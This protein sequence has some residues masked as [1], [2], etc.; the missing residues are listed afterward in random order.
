M[1][2]A[3][4]RRR[5]NSAV[6][7]AGVDLSDVSEHLLSATRDLACTYLAAEIHAVHV[8]PNEPI[9]LL[10]ERARTTAL[11]EIARVESAK[12]ELRRLC[13][14]IVG[15]RL[16]WFVHAPTGDVVDELT[17]IA[18]DV[19]ADLVVL[20]SRGSGAEDPASTVSRASRSLPCAVASVQH[21]PA[22]VRATVSRFGAYE[23]GATPQ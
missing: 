16:R 22:F 10:V 5:E 14:A 9:S 6:I 8:V 13:E 7:V 4:N 19:G 11:E 20:E 15:D 17:R 1:D 2:Q 12:R 3:T 21:D 23:R 18:H